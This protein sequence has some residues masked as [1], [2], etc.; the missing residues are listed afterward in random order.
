MTFFPWSDDYLV[1]VRIID[2]DHRDLVEIVNNLHDSIKSGGSRAEIGR[3][4]SNLATYVSEHFAREEALMAEYDYPGI[5]EHKRM[6]RRLARTVHAIR[7]LF[8]EDPSQIDPVK[9]LTFL[10]NWLVH[11]ILEEDVSYVPYLHGD[12][13]QSIRP[14]KPTDQASYLVEEDDDE[15]TELSLKVPS[16]HAATLRKCARLL[17]ENGAEAIAIEDIVA[18]LGHLTHDEA[19]RLAHPVL[20]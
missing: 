13:G 3:V 11:H 9:L 12:G 7:K 4:I 19:R 8:G 20:R 14:A 16:R 6:H 15:E 17:A 18:P 5:T 10:K 1:H 2:N